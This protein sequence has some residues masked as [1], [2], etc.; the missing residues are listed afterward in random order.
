M[1]STQNQPILNVFK[2]LV[3]TFFLL[4]LFQFAACS[5]GEGNQSLESEN[6]SMQNTPS[7]VKPK[8][9][10]VKIK[11]PCPDDP[12]CGRSRN[13]GAMGYRVEIH[14]DTL[15]T[16]NDADSIFIK[17]KPWVVNGDSMPELKY[18]YFDTIFQ[19]NVS[20][21]EGRLAFES[22]IDTC[23]EGLKLYSA[24][25]LSILRG[26]NKEDFEVRKNTT[27]ERDCYIL[28]EK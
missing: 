14:F 27:A 2:F 15:L 17:L 19:H 28:P 24:S 23:G 22:S 9:K 16:F 25:K 21:V 8:L 26:G 3:F 1:M 20:S 6:K 10:K 5:W 13:D 11:N 12:D 4:S 18:E 7:I